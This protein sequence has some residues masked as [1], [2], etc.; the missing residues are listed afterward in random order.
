MER[1]VNK[2]NNISNR[3]SKLLMRIVGNLQKEQECEQLAFPCAGHLCAR[4][5]ATKRRC[6]Q[7]IVIIADGLGRKE[8]K[9]QTRGGPR[10]SCKFS[11]NMRRA[12]GANLFVDKFISGDIHRRHLRRL[13]RGDCSIRIGIS[14]TAVTNGQRGD[15]KKKNTI[16]VNYQ[17]SAPDDEWIGISTAQLK[18]LRLVLQCKQ[19][20]GMFPPNI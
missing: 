1:E 4:I 3:S 15:L 2:S 8:T 18:V 10:F 13:I 17:A 20:R 11:H 16:S 14:F 19:E 9:Q 7:D 6:Q 12:I 5:H